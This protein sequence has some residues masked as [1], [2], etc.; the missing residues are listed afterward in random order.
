M[1]KKKLFVKE[2]Y[3]ESFKYL[4]ISFYKN[5][6]YSI[7]KKKIKNIVQNSIRKGECIEYEK[8]ERILIVLN[9]TKKIIT[10]DI[11]LEIN[12]E[13]KKNIFKIEFINFINK[14]KI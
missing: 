8:I 12:Q 3:F 5:L 14:I 9:K 1:K 7:L 11:F 4:M 10:G 6:L 2:K 13:L